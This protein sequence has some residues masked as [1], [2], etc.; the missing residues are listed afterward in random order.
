MT[1]VLHF[2]GHD[3]VDLRAAASGPASGV[4]VLL[5][6]GGGQTRRA[7]R[8][9]AEVIAAQGYRA[10]ALDLRGHGESAWCADGNYALTHFAEDIVAVTRQ[11]A[12]RPHYVGASLGGL[13]GLLAEGDLN[14]GGFAS[15]TLVDITPN[16]SPDGVAR[17]TGFMAKHMEEGFAS[18]EEAAEAIAAYTPH[19]ER[20]GPSDSLKH[21]LRLGDDGRFRWHWDPAFITGIDAETENMTQRLENTA[22]ALR[23]PVHL[24][25]GQSS[26]LVT[27]AAAQDFLKLVPHAR[28][29]DI[30]GTG[31]MVVGDR[32]D[33]FCDVILGFLRQLAETT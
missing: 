11:L 14:P 1:Q 27:E 31:H 32:N 12:A 5:V 19:R 17:I 18:P 8:R 20:R 2:Q 13:S 6:H 4:P 21:Y 25:R 30:A 9:A 7:W 22:R 23:L 29:D 24:V 15:L 16:M 3:G 28:Y 26:D 33:V 10:I